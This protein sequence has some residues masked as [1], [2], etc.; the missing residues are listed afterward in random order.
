MRSSPDAGAV[1]AAGGAGRRFG[2]A[3]RKQYLEIGGEPVLL[4]AIRPFLEH[5]RVARVVVVLPAA[6]AGD[7]PSWLAA[8]PVE[9]V[10]G[11]AERGDSVLAG[12]LRVPEAL[13]LVLVHDGARP[14][15]T[16]ELIDRVLAGCTGG[17]GAVAALP[18]TDTLKRADPEGRITHTLDRTGLWRAQTPQGFPRAGLLL[19]CRSA[20]DAGAAATDDA[21]LFERYAGPVDVVSGDP[22]NLK[23]T[24]PEDLPLAEAIAALR[25]AHA[26]GR[27]A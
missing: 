12:L 27:T 10:A 20:R 16:R 15:V 8:L 19:A 26:T 14:F 21:A 9:I 2:G 3:V 13:P 6:D 18:V 25:S 11:G 1:V 22:A 17:R 4:R 5:P 7:P 23:V 24:L